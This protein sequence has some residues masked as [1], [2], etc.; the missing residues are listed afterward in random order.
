MKVVRIISVLT[1]RSND[2]SINRMPTC[3]DR[4]TTFNLLFRLPANI[5]KDKV[6]V[7]HVSSSRSQT[8]SNGLC[9]SATVSLLSLL[10]L[11]ASVRTKDESQCSVCMK[12]VS[13]LRKIQM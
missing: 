6:T 9:S 11:S 4:E 5:N 1:K 2:Q 12:C 13:K 3:L 10:P 8:R 7:T